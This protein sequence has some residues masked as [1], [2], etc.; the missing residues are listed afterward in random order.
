MRR[1][2]LIAGSILLGIALGSGPIG[3]I[4]PA[5]AGQ[6]QT[7]S[8]ERIVIESLTDLPVHT[9]PVTLSASELLAADEPFTKLLQ[10]MRADLEGDLARYEVKDA[11]T[12]QKWH[13]T[14]CLIDLLEGRDDEALEQ[15][16]QVRALEDKEANRLMAGLVTRAIVAARRAADPQDEEA[17]YKAA[18]SRELRRLL[19][20]MDWDVVQDQVQQAKGSVE[21]ISEN[22][23]LGVAQSQLDP[24]LAK[25][26]EL[27]GDLAQH[28]VN[29][30]VGLRLVLPLKE[31]QRAVYG[32]IVSSHQTAKQDIWADRELSLA[33]GDAQADVVIG[34]WDSG[35]DLAVLGDQVYVNPDEKPDG[36]DDDGNGFVDDVNGIAFDLDGRATPELLH[37]LDEIGAAVDLTLD[38]MKG[39]MDLQAT[40]DS[41]EATALKTHISGLQP[42]E[43]ERFL[44]ELGFAG[45]YAHGTHVAG[46]AVNGNPSAR[47]LPARLTFDYHPIPAP[48]AE[49][50]ARRHAAGYGRTTAYFQDHGVR[51]VNMSWGWGYREIESN[52]EANGIGETAEARTELARHLLD[53]LS[54]GLRSAM[55]ATP[56]ILYVAAAGNS[57]SDV[58]FDIFIPSSFELPN[59]LVVGAV[60]QAGE[61]TGFTST[62][63]NVVVY[64]NGF[65]VES[66][67]PGGRRLALSGTSMA[68]PNVTNLAAKLLAL[69]PSLSPQEVIALVLDG[70]D[71]LQDQPDLKLMNPQ[72]SAQLLRERL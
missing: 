8:Q 59:L 12:L 24:I 63:K 47:V 38:H 56:D 29:L 70:A 23:I 35:V 34:I 16:A 65:E 13:R 58:A 52:L 6:E 62:G 46:I 71:A 42:Q 17:A 10:A 55:A 40:I 7:T 68:A 60:D 11:A 41:P 15:L 26:G 64:A 39:F 49:E 2:S 53:I 21:I 1:A 57:D 67:V 72:H 25:T 37:P 51:V 61:R 22:L 30:R 19:T 20:E 48:L 44:T 28:M 9:Y 54:D 45:L 14:L 27:S 69:D 36:S 3:A 50:I 43:V 66:W 33:A 32:E 18:F 5:T 4:S 31:E